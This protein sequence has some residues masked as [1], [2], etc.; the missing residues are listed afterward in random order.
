[1]RVRACVYR[2][3]FLRVCAWCAFQRLCDP[4][5]SPS[6]SSVPRWAGGSLLG[7]AGTSRLVPH[8]STHLVRLRGRCTR[9]CPLVCVNQGCLEFNR[10]QHLFR[11]VVC[12]RVH[13]LEEYPGTRVWALFVSACVSANTCVGSVL[14][15]IY[16]HSLWCFYDRAR[17]A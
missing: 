4:Q 15:H 10:F 7:P 14:R 5:T 1:M 6:P 8:T 12:V 16:E 13:A 11:F 9:V 2:L 3:A 17:V